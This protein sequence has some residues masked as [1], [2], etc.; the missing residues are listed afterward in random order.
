MQRLFSSLLLLIASGVLNAEPLQPG[1]LYGGG[2]ELAVPTLGLSIT[3]P[4]GW[5][6]MLP[7]NATTFVMES[8]ATQ[9][10]VFLLGDE[11]SK[12]ALRRTMSSPIPLDAGLLLQPAGDVRISDGWFEAD[13]SVTG[14]PTLRARIKA[15]TGM[16][17]IAL[18][19]IAIS[20]EARFDDAW[21]GADA[22]ARSLRFSEPVQPPAPPGLEGSWQDYMTGRY[23]VRLYTGSGYYEEEHIWLCSNGSFFRSS[24]AGGSSSFGGASAAY[25]GRGEGVWKAEGELADSG[26]LILR[27]G[28]TSFEGNA[29]FGSWQTS[30]GP[31][32]LHYD[33]RMADDKLYLNDKRWF[34]DGNERC[35]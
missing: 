30:G 31:K 22:V 8:E 3:L 34:R 19:I 10:N 16:S 28:A 24:S 7:N 1:R 11:I 25:G 2:T 18:A 32:E 4:E 29:T 13:Y 21:S 20:D 9:A 6:G 14:Q 27:Y 17:G 15:Q 12:E 5:K 23:V 35:Q 33:L 26:Q